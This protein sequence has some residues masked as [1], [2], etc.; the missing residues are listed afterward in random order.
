M[1]TVPGQQSHELY[2]HVC[3]KEQYNTCAGRTIAA[4]ILFFVPCVVQRTIREIHIIKNIH[5]QN[6]P[7][8]QINDAIKFISTLLFSLSY[9]VLALQ[10]ALRPSDPQLIHLTFHGGLDSYS[11]TFRADGSTR[12]TGRHHS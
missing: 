7:L 5:A 11:M 2:N 4:I 8:L 10:G 3:V 6:N 9:G 12:K 1:L